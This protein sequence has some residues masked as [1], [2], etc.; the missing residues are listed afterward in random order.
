MAGWHKSTR[1]QP[2]CQDTLEKFWEYSAFLANSLI[3]LLVGLTIAESSFFEQISL[4]APQSLVIPLGL[5]VVTVVVARAVV[6]F[7]LLTLLN[8]VSTA[9]VERRYQLVGMWGGLRGAVCL[10]LVLSLETDFPNRD[11]IVALT[12]GVVL[13]TLLIPG[14]T[15]GQLIRTLKLDRPGVVDRWQ[16][17]V[18]QV[19]IKQNALEQVPL[20]Q[21]FQPQF[22]TVIDEFQH[23][24]QREL[25]KAKQALEEFSDELNRRPENLQSLLLLTTLSV[26]QKSYRTFYAT[27]VMSEVVLD[28]LNARLSLFEDAVLSQN[29]PFLSQHY[30]F[31]WPD[32]SPVENGVSRYLQALV[33]WID[34]N[35]AWLIRHRTEMAIARYEYWSILMRISDLVSEKLSFFKEQGGDN[36]AAPIQICLELYAKE[37]EK[38]Q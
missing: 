37:K 21:A 26:E 7:G 29:L 8:R 16:Q 18:A 10:A 4:T 27:G 20:V 12:L 22:Q 5:T 2:N 6:V 28:Q 35:N 32:F 24:R 1:L 19:V 38:A 31:E 3:F 14:T 13:F 15:V 36:F 11:L 23:H 34:P 9:K 30:P 33:Q 17:C 25:T